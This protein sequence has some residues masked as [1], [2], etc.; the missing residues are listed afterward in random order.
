MIGC[1]LLLLIGLILIAALGP[2]FG[3]IVL[4]TLILFVLILNGIV[5][6]IGKAFGAVSSHDDHN[7]E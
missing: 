6:L 5:N 2:M 3:C 1:V 4:L 7:H